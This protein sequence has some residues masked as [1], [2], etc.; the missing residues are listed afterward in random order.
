MENLLNEDQAATRACLSKR[1][2]Q[3]LRCVGGGPRFIRLGRAVRYDPADLDAWIDAGRRRSTS[4]PGLAV[5]VKPEPTAPE[6]APMADDAAGIDYNY[7]AGLMARAKREGA[8]QA[9]EGER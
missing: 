1:T 8:P 6:A 2:L 3:K 9:Q 7:V 4:D 5:A